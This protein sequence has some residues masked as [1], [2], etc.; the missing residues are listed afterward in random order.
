MATTGENGDAR[1]YRQFR[2]AGTDRGLHRQFHRW[3]TR[4]LP[5]PVKMPVRYRRFR[6]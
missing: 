6:R 1:G 2:L 4:G 3:S 5:A